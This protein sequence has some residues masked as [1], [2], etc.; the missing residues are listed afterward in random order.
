MDAVNKNSQVLDE[1]KQW[2]KGWPIPALPRLSSSR[3]GQ[4]EKSTFGKNLKQEGE[5][6]GS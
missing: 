2:V 5:Y 1:L 6:V 4:N 3:N